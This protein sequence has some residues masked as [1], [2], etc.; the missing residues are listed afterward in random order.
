M[1]NNLEARYCSYLPL[2]HTGD[3]HPLITGNIG[4]IG[5]RCVRIGTLMGGRCAL[6]A[7]LRSMSPEEHRSPTLVQADVLRRELSE[8]LFHEWTDE[9]WECDIP[10]TCFV[11]KPS[12]LQFLYDTLHVYTQELGY[13]VFYLYHAYELEFHPKIYV[14]GQYHHV[15][16]SVERTEELEIMNSRSGFH[17][18]TSTL[19]VVPMH[20][21]ENVRS[22]IAI[23]VLHH[24]SVRYDT[25]HYE[26]IGYREDELDPVLTMFPLDHPL[27]QALDQWASRPGGDMAREI[28]MTLERKLDESGIDSEREKVVSASPVP[29][30]E[31]RHKPIKLPRFPLYSISG[32]EYPLLRRTLDRQVVGGINKCI[33]CLVKRHVCRCFHRGT[34][35]VKQMEEAETYLKSRKRVHFREQKL[36]YGTE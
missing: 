23:V 30:P 7:L 14:I 10:R 35:T 18:L 32:K 17:H 21:H 13:A 20:A 1:S 36:Q 9:R 6:G 16:E 2:N 8:M 22:R 24:G 27:I 11:H 3:V 34:A 29:V 31:W 25:G 26:T 4:E 19:T 15:D 28:E 12:R 33:T 5:T